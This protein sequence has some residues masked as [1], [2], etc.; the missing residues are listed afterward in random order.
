MDGVWECS[1]PFHAILIRGNAGVYTGKP[2][3]NVLDTDPRTRDKTLE[4]LQA[5]EE[6]DVV[7]V[8]G[9]WRWLTGRKLHE[10]SDP[11]WTTL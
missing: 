6:G 8:D 10:R 5:Q 1:A 4:I 2:D 11:E 9:Q 3:E 7:N